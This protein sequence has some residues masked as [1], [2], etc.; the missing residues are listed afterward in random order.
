MLHCHLTGNITYFGM[1][2][3]HEGTSF[4]H[5]RTSLYF[6]LNKK[7]AGSTKTSV[8]TYQTKRYNSMFF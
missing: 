1:Y 4:P 2:K 3:G 7:K 6:I 5:I 8:P